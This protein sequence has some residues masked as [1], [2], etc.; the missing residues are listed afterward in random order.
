MI[1]LP[2][3]YQD[4]YP[5]IN[6][7]GYT[8]VIY[9]SLDYQYAFKIYKKQFKY[10]EEKFNEFLKFTNPNCFTPKDLVSIE[11]ANNLAGYKMLYDAGTSLPNLTDVSLSMLIKSAS[12][13]NPTLQDLSQYHFLITD[14]NVDNITFSNTYKFVDTYNF[15]HAKKFS[16]EKIQQRNLLR[17]NE[18]I[19]CG[20]MGFSYRNRIIKYL[21]T[22]QS[23]HLNIFLNLDKNNP[24]FVYE[25]LSII[26]DTTNQDQLNKAKK[27]ILALTKKY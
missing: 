10:D 1:I 17:V 25:A 7:T 6:E 20:L 23:K 4:I 14:P 16:A 12:D 5:C 11:N 15:L 27:N 8:A 18:S 21:N 19:L 26:Q 22:I 2:K 13:I 3:N 24:N 9:A